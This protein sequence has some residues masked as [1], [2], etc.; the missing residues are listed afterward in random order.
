MTAYVPGRIY[1]V[2][3]ELHANI[4]CAIASFENGLV[5]VVCGKYASRLLDDL[6]SLFSAYSASGNLTADESE[7]GS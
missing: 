3:K 5:K 7:V 2:S 4:L 1:S 6:L